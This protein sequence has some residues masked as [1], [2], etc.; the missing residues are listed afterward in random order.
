MMKFNIKNVDVT[1]PL[2]AQ[3]SS[4]T[5]RKLSEALMEGLYDMTCKLTWK[6][7]LGLS[8]PQVLRLAAVASSKG[9]TPYYSM[10]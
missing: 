4:G 2:N 8:S 7:H 6:H 10:V 9:G 5:L 1:D 3:P